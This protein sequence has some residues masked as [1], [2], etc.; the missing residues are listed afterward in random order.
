MEPFNANQPLDDVFVDQSATAKP[1][2]NFWLRFAALL[3]DGF[4][5][6]F[7][8]FILGFLLMGGMFFRMMAGMETG[9]Y[10]PTDADMMKFLIS[11]FTLIGVSIVGQWLYFALMESSKYQATLGKMAVGIKVVDLNGNKISFGKATGR[12]FGKIISGAIF[13][14]GYI[15]AAFTERKQALHDMMANTLVTLK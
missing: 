1:Y 12:F 2:A 6:S 13:Y 14:V 5:F 10:E 11:Y 9:G 15:M 4:A 7:V 3:I 8:F